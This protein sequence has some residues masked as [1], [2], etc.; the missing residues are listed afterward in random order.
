MCAGGINKV[1]ST[2]EREEMRSPAE[3]GE[4]REYFRKK[5][6]IEDKPLREEK[7]GEW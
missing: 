1:W 2:T 7:D 5:V 4:V 6:D 3:V